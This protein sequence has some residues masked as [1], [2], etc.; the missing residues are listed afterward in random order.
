M[1]NVSHDSFNLI[2][3]IIKDISEGFGVGEGGISERA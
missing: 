1:K 2:L 3:Q